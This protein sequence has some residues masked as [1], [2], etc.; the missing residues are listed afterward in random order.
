MASPLVGEEE[1]VPVFKD[2]YFPFSPRVPGN[3]IYE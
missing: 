2:T 3:E 1:H